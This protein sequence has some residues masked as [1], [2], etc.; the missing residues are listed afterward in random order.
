MREEG[1][2]K[3]KGYFIYVCRKKRYVSMFY[4]VIK[5]IS[6]EYDLCNS[7]KGNC[8]YESSN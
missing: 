5:L 3:Q 8:L 4:E 7:Y 2:D 6:T 1:A